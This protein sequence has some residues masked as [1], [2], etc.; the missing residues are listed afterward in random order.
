M[1]EENTLPATKPTLPGPPK[2]EEPLSPRWDKITK[3]I[4]WMILLGIFIFL[5]SRFNNYLN[6]VITAFLISILVQPLAKLLHRYLRLSW[7]LAVVLVYFI[8]FSFLIFLVAR[9]GVFILDQVRSFMDTWKVSVLPFIESLSEMPLHLGPFSFQLPKLDT[10]F[11]VNTIQERL[12]PLAGQAPGAVGK[13]VS[14]LGGFLFNFF[15]TFMV[16][17]FI[18]SESET[19]NGRFFQ[20]KIPGYEYDIKRMGRELTNTW[21]A[22]IRGE[23][24]IIGAAILIY[25]TLLGVLG[26]PNFVVLGIIAGLGRLV[27]YLGAWV[28]WLT[29][30]FTAFFMKTNIFGVKPIVF[31]LIVVAIALFIDSILDNVLTPR[32]M[33]NALEVHPAAILIAAL[34]MANLFGLLGIVLAAP[35]LASLKLFLRYVLRKLM[36][37][38]P[39][40]GISYYQKPKRSALAKLIKRNTTLARWFNAIANKVSEFFD[41]IAE[42][43]K[44]LFKKIALNNGIKARKAAKDQREKQENETSAK[45][46]KPKPKQK[47][48]SDK[49]EQ[50]RNS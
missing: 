7:R 21:S 43:I 49:I 16:S 15:L 36:D 1:S 10:N 26:L 32:V 45:A 38:D 31:A 2:D 3:M 42:S 46:S 27:P 35:V 6:L 19:T 25:S 4:V 47:A 39:W 28:G 11:L 14:V 40:E 12:L 24:I 5:V 44:S 30:G 18:T 13:T 29:F 48:N 34:V 33:G 8:I 17:L 9:S 37:Q 50:N 41:R 23:F 20:I 22:F